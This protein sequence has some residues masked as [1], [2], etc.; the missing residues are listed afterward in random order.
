LVFIASVEG[1]GQQLIGAQWEVG[2]PFIFS[3][4]ELS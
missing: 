2:T 3:H 4:L 1:I